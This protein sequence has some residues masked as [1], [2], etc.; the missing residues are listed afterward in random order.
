MDEIVRTARAEPDIVGYEWSLGEDLERFVD[1]IEPLSFSVYGE[2]DDELW[3]MLSPLGAA[4]FE[5]QGGFT[6]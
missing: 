4:Y 3:A 1:L 5:R 2:V 6:R